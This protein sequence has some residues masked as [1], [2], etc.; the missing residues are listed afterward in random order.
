MIFLSR[1]RDPLDSEVPPML[2]SSA[3]RRMDMKVLSR[4]LLSMAIIGVLALPA[5]V[6]GCGARVSSGYR[7]YD[8]DYRDYH[9]WDGTEVGFYGQ[10]E[11]DTH[12]DHR[13]FR[14]R[15]ESE[16]KEY[17]KWRHDHH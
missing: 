11:S 13:D 9:A 6:V 15:S 2:L 17:W 16:Q 1:I 12:R 10:W 3:S 8:P 14:K 4:F 5:L 7:V